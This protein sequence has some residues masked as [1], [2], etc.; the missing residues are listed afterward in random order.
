MDLTFVA[1]AGGGIPMV[2]R[3]QLSATNI[4]RPQ[5]TSAYFQQVTPVTRY[6]PYASELIGYSDVCS[7]VDCFLVK[8]NVHVLKYLKF[9]KSSTCT[10]AHLFTK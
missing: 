2:N 1:P 5:N 3:R 9:S 6:A 8:Y 4:N 7:C 10:H